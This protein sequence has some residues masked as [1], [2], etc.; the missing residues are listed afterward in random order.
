M[1]LSGLNKDEEALKALERALRINPDYADAQNARNFVSS[2]LGIAM[3]EEEEEIKEKKK[4]KTRRSVWTIKKPT[5]EIIEKS[6]GKNL[7]KRSEKEG[8]GTKGS[9][10][11]RK[12][13]KRK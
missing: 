10:W 13:P 9:E 5:S 2:R 4:S 7:G 11:S 1:A 8:E 6:S 3:D 12:E